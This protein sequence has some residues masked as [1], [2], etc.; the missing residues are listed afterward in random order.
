MMNATSSGDWVVRFGV[1]DKDWALLKKG[2]VAMVK[3]D[4][5]P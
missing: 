4:A 3:I 5:Y 2:N 1:S